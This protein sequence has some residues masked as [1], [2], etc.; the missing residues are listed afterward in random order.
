[1]LIPHSILLF[2]QHFPCL[3]AKAPSLHS[4]KYTVARTSKHAHTLLFTSDVVLSFFPPVDHLVVVIEEVLCNASIGPIIGTK[5]W[6]EGNIMIL[7]FN[8]FFMLNTMFCSIRTHFKKFVKEYNQPWKL[9][10]INLLLV[11]A[12]QVSSF[13]CKKI[14]HKYNID[15]HKHVVLMWEGRWHCVLCF[16]VPFWRFPGHI[17]SWWGWNCSWRRDSIW[18]W[19]RRKIKIK[20]LD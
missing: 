10:Y 9:I 2:L 7:Y 12:L 4:H 16:T 5:K 8:F 1:M 11:N 20:L 17:E 14:A 15:Q 19:N 13:L 18:S 6:N 3:Y